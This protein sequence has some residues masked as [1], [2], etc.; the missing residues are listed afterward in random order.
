MQDR[1]FENWSIS[2]DTV[3]PSRVYPLGRGMEVT[4]HIDSID[5]ATFAMVWSMAA[6]RAQIDKLLM[7]EV[8]S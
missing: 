8:W 6:Q 5:R 1:E 3:R 4:E 7:D 2:L